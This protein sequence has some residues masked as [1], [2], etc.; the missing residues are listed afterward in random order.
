[1]LDKFIYIKDFLTKG[2][3][4]LRLSDFSPRKAM[5]IKALKILVIAIRGIYE[6]KIQQ[7]AAALTLY[8]IL[9]IVPILAMGFGIAKGF[10]FAKTLE[11][12]IRTKL[13]EYQDIVEKLIT[14]ANQMLVRTKGGLVATVGFVLLIYTILKVFNNVE[15]SFNDIWQVRKGRTYVRKISDYLAMMIISPIFFVTAS[16]VNVYITDKL[17]AINRHVEVVNIIS[18]VL[19]SALKV[20]PFLLII[21]LFMLLY[22]TMPN[23]KVTFKAGLLAGVI[24]GTAFQITQWAYIYFQIGVSNYN[25]IYGSFAAIPLFII[26]LQISWLI[27]LFGAKISYATQNYEM[28]EFEM[29]T[30]QMSEY[31][32][33]I[34]SL[35]TTHRIIENFKKGVHP[36][37]AS[38]LSLELRIPIRMLKIILS[39]LMKCKIISEVIT[40]K[41]KINAYQPAQNIE[42]LSIKYVME[43][44]DKLGEHYSVEEHSEVTR[45]LVEIHEKFFK[46]I[47]TL[48]ENLLI[49]DM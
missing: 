22:I 29:E 36:P 16:A 10:G 23:T 12:Q 19:F 46:T 32:R 47:E 2:L 27:V 1:M 28:H 14:F 11:D 4:S 45:K 37:T 8:T 39:D 48:P 30:M 6:D 18:P 35:L 42:H 25:A 26:W 49:K 21:V 31:S 43:K 33:R 9:S 38:E 7:R 13:V 41:P 40:D 15:S 5:Q 44:L 34:L 17:H 20:V 24:A 3:W